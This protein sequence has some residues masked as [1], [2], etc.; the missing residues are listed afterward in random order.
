MVP[1]TILKMCRFILSLAQLGNNNQ[2]KIH[3]WQLPKSLNQFVYLM[4]LLSFPP[5]LIW[6]CIDE[7]FKLNKTAGAMGLTF[8]STQMIL[9][10][11]S[12]AANN[13]LIVET[14]DAIQLIVNER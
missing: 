9:I 8:G 10:Y 4:P 2:F 6:Y 14:F 5:Y 3:R 11:L 7:D 13:E 12:L 1:S